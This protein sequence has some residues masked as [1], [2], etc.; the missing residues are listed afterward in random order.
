VI[1]INKKAV[2]IF[3]ALLIGVVVLFNLQ[4]RQKENLKQ[5]TNTPQNTNTE[6][7][8]AANPQTALDFNSVTGTDDQTTEEPNTLGTTEP[9]PAPVKTS[10]DTTITFPTQP[11][12]KSGII[13]T[14]SSTNETAIKNYVDS[15]EQALVGFNLTKDG[16]SIQSQ[17]QTL[18]KSVLEALKNKTIQKKTAIAAI[19]V[20]A[21]ALGVAQRYYLVYQYYEDFLNQTLALINRTAPDQ[22]AA[23]DN[24]EKIHNQLEAAMEDLGVDL[25][26]LSK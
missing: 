17:Y 18:D 24:L 7:E 26:T 3:I 4:A 1:A 25:N 16:D 11:G 13:Q 19:S 10:T 2:L 15:V 12:F 8:P 21:P 5:L 22:N 23:L 6:F 14:N 9:A 20:P